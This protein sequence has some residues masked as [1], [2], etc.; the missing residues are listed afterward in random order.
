MNIKLKTEILNYK[1][2]P[3]TLTRKTFIDWIYWVNINRNK[4]V[5]YFII[6]YNSSFLT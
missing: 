6:D 2:E 5:E 4:E 1:I 3:C